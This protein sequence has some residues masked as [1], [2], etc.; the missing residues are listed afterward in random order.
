MP[1][2]HVRDHVGDGDLL[3]PAQGRGEALLGGGELD[4]VVR[5]RRCSLD[6]C[7]DGPDAELDASHR[8]VSSPM[9]CCWGGA[10]P[11][12]ASLR[13]SRKSSSL[14][15]E[16]P[17][18]DALADAEAL[19]DLGHRRR[20]VAVSAKRWAANVHELAAPF[21][22]PLGQPR[23]IGHGTVRDHLTDGQGTVQFARQP[24]LAGRKHGVH[25]RPYRWPPWP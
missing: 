13:I 23:F 4:E 6:H 20:V 17:V 10:G 16:V 15:V 1:S 2:L 7:I 18:E 3:A 5:G 9:A 8:V 22:A 12:C 25:T 14:R 11:C 21:L 19:H 24:M